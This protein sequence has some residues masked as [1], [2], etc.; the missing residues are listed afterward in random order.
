MD[1]VALGIDFFLVKWQNILF[2]SRVVFYLLFLSHKNNLFDLDG[3][4]KRGEECLST[5]R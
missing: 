5:R 3:Y 2:T 1:S 4:T